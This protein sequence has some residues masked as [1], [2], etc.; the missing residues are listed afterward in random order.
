MKKTQN[1]SSMESTQID[2]NQVVSVEYPD[3][4]GNH[5]TTVAELRT[6]FMEESNE[7]R[8]NFFND[9]ITKSIA[10]SRFGEYRLL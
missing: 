8:K 6:R 9:L 7:W 5:K 2:L 10:H 4:K 3:G 1:T